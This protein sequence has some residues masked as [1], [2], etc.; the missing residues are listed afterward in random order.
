[1][2]KG[3]SK[4]IWFRALIVLL[5]FTVVG[6]GA[7]GFGLINT[8]FVNGE[9]YAKLAEQQQLQDIVTKAK[10]GDIYDRNM[11]VLAT[12]ATV[13]QVYATP[14]SIEEEK[15]PLIAEN[16]AKIMDLE[17]D[18]VKEYLNKNTSYQNIGSPV[19]QNVANKVREYISEEKLGSVIGLSETNERYYSNDNLASTVLG[20]VGTDNQG[21]DGIEAQ[22]DSTLTG[23]EGRV[24]AAKTPAGS[25]LPFSYEKVVDAKAGN[26]LVL[27]IDE[28]IQSV[29]EKY[30]EENVEENK[31]QN[32]AAC[33]VMDVNSGEILAMATKPDFNPNEPFSITLQDE[34]DEDVEKLKEKGEYSE[35]KESELRSL[36]LQN[37]WRN[38]A[39]T[40]TYEPGSVF[41]IITASAALEEKTL[42][43]SDTFDCPGY[44]KIADRTYKC[45]KRAGHGHQSLAQAF[46]NSCNPAFITIG[47]RLGADNF[48]KYRKSFGLEDKTGIDLPGE[49]S[50]ISHNTAKMSQVELASESFGQTLRITPIQ[51]ITAISAAVNGGYVYQPHVVKQIQ[52]SDG[53]VVENIDSTLV[54]QVISEETSQAICKYLE[55]VVSEGTGKNAYIPGY[56]IGGKTGTAGKTDTGEEDS[57]IKKYVCSF[58]GIA[59]ADDPEIAILMI[60][61]EPGVPNPYGGTLVAPSVG[62]MFEEIL[63]YLGVTPSY[64]DSEAKDLAVST[65][66]VVKLSTKEA[67]KKIEEA[68]LVCSVIGDGKT[69]EAQ[70]P[71]GSSTIPAGG[72]VILYTD[73]K[74]KR[75]KVKVPD[76][77]GLT[78]SQAN[79]VATN[80]GLNMYIN[81]NTTDSTAYS[82]S[83]ETGKSVE[84]GTVITVSF[85]EVVNVE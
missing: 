23:T 40:E 17:V 67:K 35:E 38:K 9:R 56:R 15:K 74:E 57:G 72:K 84:E 65:P 37:Q 54:R 25:E 80:A 58:C 53:N 32:R 30:L 50:S 43:D 13:W 42:S 75:R 78:V 33:I 1:M 6:F 60:I 63:P 31:V 62:K 41:K 5:I 68:G 10:R 81:G 77:T 73:E 7:T 34:L 29:V 48:A 14:S 44:I 51:M 3:E 11:N 19:E 39:V 55:G 69:V 64:T 46:M 52:N 79:E 83:L 47:Q 2:A 82:Q 45:A 21:L 36:A 27:T 28:Y 16:L 22:Y 70:S 20:F 71:L 49:T 85:R 8:I 59:P 26:S 76:F 66:N 24:I 4:S 18:K 12:S 61:D